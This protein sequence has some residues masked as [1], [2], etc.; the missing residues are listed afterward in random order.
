[1]TYNDFKMCC[2]LFCKH[3]NGQKYGCII[4]DCYSNDADILIN[5]RVRYENIYDDELVRLYFKDH[6]MAR[7]K[8]GSFT[9]IT[10]RQ[11]LNFHNTID[12]LEYFKIPSEDIV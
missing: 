2:T 1:M 10:K 6:Y 5:G 4:K 8:D 3:F 7:F 11:N 12:F 9:I